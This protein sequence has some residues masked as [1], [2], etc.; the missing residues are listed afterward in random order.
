MLLFLQKGN[1]FFV[2]TQRE[3]SLKEE[4]KP[5][6]HHKL[7]SQEEVSLLDFSSIP[8]HVAIIMDGNRRWE[9]EHGMPLFSGHWKGAEI[10]TQIVRAASELGI[11]TLTV[12]AFSTENWMRSDIEVESLMRLFEIYLIQQKESMVEEGV[13]LHAIGD[14]DKL[15]QRIQKVVADT[16]AA[17]KEGSQIE[18]VLAINYGSRNEIIRA[19]QKMIKAAKEEKISESEIDETLVSKFLDTA[20]LSDPDLLIRTSGE[21]RLS[22]FLLW[23]ASYTELYVEKVF[24]PDFSEKH[25]LKAILEY[26]KRKRRLGGS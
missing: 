6:F 23:Q 19:I 26:Q 14:L 17:T 5:T 4:K 8:K 22:N 2:L 15:P 12:F 1:A 7:F 11:Q 9:K 18:L 25:F 3:L 21:Q 16:K 24:W 20:T 10:L 13:R